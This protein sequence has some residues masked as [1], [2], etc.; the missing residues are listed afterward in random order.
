MKTSKIN[1]NNTSFGMAL[2]PPENPTKFANIVKLTNENWIV[3]NTAKRGLKKIIKQNKNIPYNIK[4]NS[5]ENCFEVLSKDNQDIFLSRFQVGTGPKI[6]NTDL[7]GL[8]KITKIIN[9]ILFKPENSLP[10]ALREASKR[11]CEYNEADLKREA[12]N[13][14][15][16]NRIADA[17]YTINELFKKQ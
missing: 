12:E 3:R 11:A 6:I 17:I 5:Q 7:S 2:L 16:R 8:K 10:T 1:T 9:T 4:Y 14:V 15:S 13:E